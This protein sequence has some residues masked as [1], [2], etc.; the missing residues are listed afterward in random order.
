MD[1]SRDEP[2][3]PSPHA[4]VDGLGYTGRPGGD[5]EPT[6]AGDDVAGLGF[7][8]RDTPDEYDGDRFSGE[9]NIEPDIEPDAAPEV[10]PEATTEAMPGE[11]AD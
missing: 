11:D 5:D 6:A 7:G 8:G 1:E 9:P 2:Q 3:Q 10:T 4:G